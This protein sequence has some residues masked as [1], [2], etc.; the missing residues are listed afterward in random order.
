MK[1]LIDSCVLISAS[2]YF[3]FKNKTIKELEYENSLRFFSILKGRGDLGY[4]T[5]TIE[6]ESKNALLNAIQKSLILNMKESPT[7]RF[8]LMELQDTIFSHCLDKMDTIIEE[9]TS[10]PTIVIEQRE[11]IK[12]AEIEPFFKDIIGKTERYRTPQ[13]VPKIISK[14]GF[15]KFLKKATAISGLSRKYIYIGGAPRDNDLRLMAEAAFIYRK[16]KRIEEVYVASLDNHFVP[17]RIFIYHPDSPNREFTGSYCS[18]VRDNVKKVFGF[19][20]ERPNIITSILKE[21][22]KSK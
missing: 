2:L 13:H 19:I 16:S 18:G 9:C 4:V 7:S 11:K 10:R 17:N 20:G 5:K 12:K 1:I 6:V 22:L 21:Q 15:V 3:K 8:N 14:G